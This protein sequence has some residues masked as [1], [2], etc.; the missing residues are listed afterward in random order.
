M[1]RSAF[2]GVGMFLRF[3]RLNAQHRRSGDIHYA[4]SVALPVEAADQ[5]NRQIFALEDTRRGGSDPGLSGKRKSEHFSLGHGALIRDAGK[6]AD[7]KGSVT[8]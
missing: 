1:P 2:L 6:L 4:I 5:R 7:A 8:K 3:R